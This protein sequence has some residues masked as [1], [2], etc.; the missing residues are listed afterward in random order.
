MKTEIGLKVRIAEL[1]KVLNY[2][3]PDNLSINYMINRPKIEA[4]KEQI[5]IIEEKINKIKNFIKEC[6]FHNLK[7]K[8]KWCENSRLCISCVEAM[9]QIQVL[10][11]LL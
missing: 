4:F 10:E 11:E 8:G 9:S 6:D 5:V 7:H 1:E 3:F 2:I